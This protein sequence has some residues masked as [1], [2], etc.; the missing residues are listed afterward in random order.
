M[1]IE[2]CQNIYFDESKLQSDSCKMRCCRLACYN[3]RF[4][5]LCRI[6]TANKTIKTFII[7]ELCICCENIFYFCALYIWCFREKILTLQ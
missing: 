2:C 1:K 3:V 7:K 6:K 5:A 4:T